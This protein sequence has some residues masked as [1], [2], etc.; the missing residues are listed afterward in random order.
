MAIL[1]GNEHKTFPGELLKPVRREVRAAH[2]R[3]DAVERCLLRDT[4]EAI[5][6]EDMD[7][8]VPLLL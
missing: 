7:S 3:H 2:R 6:H 8:S 5:A 1:E 4:V